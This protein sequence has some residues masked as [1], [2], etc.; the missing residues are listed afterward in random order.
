MLYYK[1]LKGLIAMNI[2]Y[3]SKEVEDLPNGTITLYEDMNENLSIIL[4]DKHIE[5]VISIE[6][7]HFSKEDNEMITIV[8]NKKKVY[9]AILGNY[10]E[11]INIIKKLKKMKNVNVIVWAKDES[12]Y[13]VVLVKYKKIKEKDLKIIM[14]TKKG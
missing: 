9:N 7:F 10:K 12:I 4:K 2:I 8:L 3:N 14:D 1:S 6:L 13:P 5:N 11:N